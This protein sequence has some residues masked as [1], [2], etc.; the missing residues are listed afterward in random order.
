M[1]NQQQSDSMSYKYSEEQKLAQWLIQLLQTSLPPQSTTESENGN[2]GS[3]LKKDEK[4]LEPMLDRDYH[5]HFYQQIPNFAQALLQ[6]QPSVALQ[7]APLLYHLV[8]CRVCHQAYLEIYDGLAAALKSTEGQPVSVN[9]GGLSLQTPHVRLAV[10]L[11]QVLIGQAEAQL[12]LARHE[13][14]DA[15]ASVRAML[16][17]AMRLA[18]RISQSNMRTRALKDLVHVATLFDNLTAAPEAERETPEPTT[19]SYVPTF[20]G[21]G[22]ARQ[23]RTVRGV[24]APVRSADMSAEQHPQ[25]ILLQSSTLRGTIMQHEDTLELHLHNLEQPLRGR[26]LIITVPLGSLIEPVQWQGGNPRAIRSAAP[27]DK[28]GTLVTPLGQTNLRID[29]PEERNLLEVMF[30]RLD[31]RPAV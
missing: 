29:R 21:P 12:R 14:R 9:T 25:A 4:T 30:L 6:E 27:V 7:Y 16:Q 8:G 3:A 13:G 2:G 19:H 26:Y 10:H 5:P 18:V 24:E 23:G 11:C 22:D 31:V 20:A 28:D 17:L 15:D 1:D